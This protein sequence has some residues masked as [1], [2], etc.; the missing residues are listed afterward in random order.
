MTGPT[1]EQGA[2]GSGPDDPTRPLES[3]RAVPGAVIV[4]RGQLA[5]L[6]QRDPDAVPAHPSTNP[7]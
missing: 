2:D 4:P 7:V 6:A 5:R 3:L 1:P